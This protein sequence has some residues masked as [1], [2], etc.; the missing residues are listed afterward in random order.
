MRMREGM[1][2]L[3]GVE[4][5]YVLRT[6]EGCVVVK[7]EF[8]DTDYI[9][10]KILRDKWQAKEWDQS[11]YNLLYTFRRYECTKPSDRI[12]ALGGLAKDC[13]RYRPTT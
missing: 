13:W 11:L 3:R 12:Y 2:S 7:F 4:D 6:K 5:R 8:P 1:Y 9:S 10:L